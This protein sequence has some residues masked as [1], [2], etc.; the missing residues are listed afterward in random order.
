MAHAGGESRCAA[1]G[2][3]VWLPGKLGAS[4]SENHFDVVLEELTDRAVGKLLKVDTYDAPAFDAL[5]DYVWQKA[6]GLQGETTISK[7]ILLTLRSAAGAIRSRAEYLP[8]VREQLHRANDFD[9]M[10]DRLIAG[11]R[12]SDRQPGIPRVI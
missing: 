7:Q 6:E 11:E 3:G 10:L 8:A 9:M 2:K 1:D 4:V 12:R 5:E